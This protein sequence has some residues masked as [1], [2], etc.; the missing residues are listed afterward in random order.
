MSQY[1]IYQTKPGIAYAFRGWE[2]SEKIFS[3]ADYKLVYSG[4][5]VDKI[6]MNWHSDACNTNDYQ[7]LEDLFVMFNVNRPSDFTGHSLSVSDVVAITRKD[8]T[9][10]YYCDCFGWTQID[11]VKELKWVITKF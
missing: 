10:Y 11:F 3:P 9:R 7:V 1:H 5:I 8:G 2:E 6:V 4:E